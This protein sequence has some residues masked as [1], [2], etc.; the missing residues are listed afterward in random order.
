MQNRVP[1]SNQVITMECGILL[2]SQVI[3]LPYFREP[4]EKDTEEVEPKPPVSV[5]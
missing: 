2:H 1:Y 5:N 3:G 4:L